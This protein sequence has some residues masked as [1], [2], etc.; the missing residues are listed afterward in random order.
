MTVARFE[1]L[2][3][4]PIAFWINYGV[5]AVV[6]GPENYQVTGDL[7]GATSRFVEQHYLGN[8][9]PRS[10][11]GMRVR[12]RPEERATGDGS[13]PCGRAGRQEIKIRFRPRTAK[14]SRWSML[15]ARYWA[16]QC[17]GLW[18]S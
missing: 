14:I 13:S 5:H 4:K 15:S 8:D 18:R 11:A 17:S 9:R 6:M 12:L 7:A 16:R 1:D 10:D 2:T 3:G